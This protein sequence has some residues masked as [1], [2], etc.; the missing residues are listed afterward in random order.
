ML[1]IGKLR[2]IGDERTEGKEVE[3][4]AQNSE[5]AKLAPLKKMNRAVNRKI[6]V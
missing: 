6:E 1:D 2:K 3:E 4:E 5:S